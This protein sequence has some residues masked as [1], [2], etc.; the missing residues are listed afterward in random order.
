LKR[1]VC[2]P[3]DETEAAA[4]AGNGRTRELTAPGAVERGGILVDGLLPGTV[5][6][7]RVFMY[8]I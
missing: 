3:L 2:V 1:G 4:P 6:N 8:F 7:R 5:D